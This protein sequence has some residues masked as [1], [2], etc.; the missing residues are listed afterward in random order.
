MRFA[1]QRFR[2]EDGS[3]GR[4]PTPEGSIGKFR[5]G[6]Q[7]AGQPQ[8]R[9]GMSAVNA[10]SF[11]KTSEPEFNIGQFREPDFQA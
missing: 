9:A 2:S 4:P 1:G 10:G 8:S 11:T 5:Y 7:A 3:I 6:Y